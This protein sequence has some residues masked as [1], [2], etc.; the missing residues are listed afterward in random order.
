MPLVGGLVLY[1]TWSDSEVVCSREVALTSLSVQP[2]AFAAGAT[3][4]IFCSGT[5]PPSGNTSAAWA[6]LPPPL[7]AGGEPG[8][9]PRPR[10]AAEQPAGAVADELLALR[11]GAGLAL[12]LLALPPKPFLLLPAMG[13]GGEI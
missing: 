11:G 4:K 1:L 2:A 5:L 6:S 9:G 12:A 7:A 10:Q 3:S 13:H 8:S